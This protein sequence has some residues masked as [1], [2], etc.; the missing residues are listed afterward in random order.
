M[1]VRICPSLVGEGGV[2][3][4]TGVCWLP[5][6]L[7]HGKLE[8]TCLKGIR[9]REIEQDMGSLDSAHACM[10]TCA[11]TNTNYQKEN[12]Q[13]VFKFVPMCLGRR[14]RFSILQCNDRGLIWKL[15]V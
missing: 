14:C 13:D 8:R 1:A 11:H 2:R 15:N 3:E 7:N 9:K 12:P 5:T 4:I 10:H 6:Q